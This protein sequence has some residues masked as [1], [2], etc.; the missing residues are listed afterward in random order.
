MIWISL[1][2]IK[3]LKRLSK[4]VL[5]LLLLGAQGEDNK[6]PA[7]P[8]HIAVSH[9]YI[10]VLIF[11]SPI[12]EVDLAS[13]SYVAKISGNYLLLRCRRPNILPTSL[14]V[15]YAEGKAFLHTLVRFTPAPP[16][17]YDLRTY[18]P[19]AQEQ[20]EQAQTA[21]LLQGIGYLS[22]LPQ[23]YK[24]VGLKA[25]QLTLVLL[26]V[27]T[28]KE[29][30]YLRL[31]LTNDSGMDY[32]IEAV[33]FCFQ[34]GH[35]KQIEVVP[36]LAQQPC[37]EAGKQAELIYVLSAYGMKE[38]GSLALELREAS[39]ERVLQL[40]IPGPILVKAPRYTAP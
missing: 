11:D 5:L 32:T 4:L 27:L 8:A 1:K 13:D 39:G 35:K 37:V 9:R 10:T 25:D 29:Y 6:G 7:M 34:S 16:K 22:A 28:D 3:G 19:S 30:L 2:R 21:H 36:V 20:K 31:S 15:T 17:T 40:S 23:Q 38:K 26:S 24:D 18:A 33:R 12:C 14:F